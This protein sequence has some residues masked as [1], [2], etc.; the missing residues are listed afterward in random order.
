M[1]QLC[2]L[3]MLRFDLR[4]P[5]HK[6]L[7][8]RTHRPVLSTDL[9]QPNCKDIGDPRHQGETIIKNMAGTIRGVVELWHKISTKVKQNKI[10]DSKATQGPQQP[11]EPCYLPE[12]PLDIRAKIYHYVFT[13][14]PIPASSSK[15]R[16]SREKSMP[17]YVKHFE[18][19]GS[20]VCTCHQI[21]REAIYIHDAFILASCKQLRLRVKAFETIQAHAFEQWNLGFM[22][23]YTHTFV[24]YEVRHE[25]MSREQWMIFWGYV[26]MGNERRSFGDIQRFRER[27]DALLYDRF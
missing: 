8:R 25:L 5:H 23:W 13:Q 18:V 4:A 21:M 26:W 16:F 24:Y 1:C 2:S 22:L 17:L 10:I 7:L 6:V 12:L 11:Q 19:R 20:L 15:G 9:N 3:H 27:E 14:D